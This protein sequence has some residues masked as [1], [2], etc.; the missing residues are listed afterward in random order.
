MKELEQGAYYGEQGVEIKTAIGDADQL[1]IAQHNLAQTYIEQA[2]DSI[3][4]SVKKYCFSKA[5]EHANNGLLIQKQTGSIK[6]R[7]QLLTE[8]FISEFQLEALETSIL[9]SAQ[10]LSDLQ[11]WMQKEIDAGRGTTYDCNVIINELMGLIPT[12]NGRNGTDLINW[13]F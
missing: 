1:P 3:D 7:G 6:K 10:S 2:F 5:L 13:S 4:F 11:D 12:F 8:K 9:D